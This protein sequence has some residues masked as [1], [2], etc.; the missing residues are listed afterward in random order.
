MSNRTADQKLAAWKKAA[1][2]VLLIGPETLA[3][4][5]A[6]AEMTGPRC[7]HTF[8]YHGHADSRC[9]LQKGHKGQH[10]CASR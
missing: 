5:D 2:D 4:I 1:A 8:P 9:A 3:R 6:A 7:T 10:R